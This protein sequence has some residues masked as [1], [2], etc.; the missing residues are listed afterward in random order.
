MSQ[1]KPSWFANVWQ[2]TRD[3]FDRDPTDLDS[4]RPALRWLHTAW[5]FSQQVVLGFLDKRGPLRSAALCY[6]TL[7]ALVP[8]LAVVFSVSKSFLRESSAE[9]AP[10]FIDMIVAKVAPQL[11]VLPATG[12]TNVAVRAGQVKV[13][14]DARRE[15]VQS[16]QQ[17]IGNIDAGTLGT[18]GTLALIIVAIQLL[19]TIEQTFN[20]I[21]GV[22][23]GRSIWRKV[24]YYWA[25]V[26]LGPLVLLTALT[27]TGSAEFADTLNKFVHVP[28]LERFL[29]KA[30]PYA[31]LWLG[32]GALYG[33][34]PNTTVRWWAATAGGLVAGTLW[35]L[36]SILNTMYLSRVVTYS[37]IYGSLGIIPVFLIG[38]Y[39]S[40][41]IVL[42]GAQVSFA[43]QN[44]TAYLQQRASERLDQL[45][46]ER[47][48]CR[49]VLLVCRQFLNSLPP[50]TI[51][52]ISRRLTVPGSLIR[53]LT[54][55]LAEAGILTTTGTEPARIQP[56][57]LPDTFTVADVLHVLRTNNGG[58]ASATRDD[59]IVESLLGDLRAAER[60]AS[61]NLRFSDLAARAEKT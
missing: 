40:W 22:A 35:Q 15:V 39:F 18:I 42:F 10:Q 6:T 14:D 27:M 34:M 55:R 16:I 61:S 23:K 26:T 53:R 5:H 54:T 37:K 38:V 13:S 9:V 60:A 36:N 58:A 4:Y 33:L 50:L 11:E 3:F 28:F 46:R 45:G 48:A 7:L 24:I 21:W 41:M 8:L 59:D 44:H 20:D 1:S 30:I 51:E 49:L 19:M 12:A 52:E 56:A 43:V 47:L 32:F 31:I 17:F 57:R 25:S 2:Q 29:F